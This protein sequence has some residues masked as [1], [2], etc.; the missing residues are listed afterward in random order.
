M[1]PGDPSHPYLEDF[2]PFT[3]VQTFISQQLKAAS[4]QA[5]VQESLKVTSFAVVSPAP[6]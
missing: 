2:P 5:Y 1:K 4:L 6:C 3:E